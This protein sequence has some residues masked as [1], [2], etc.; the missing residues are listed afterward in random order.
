MDSEIITLGKGKYI[1]GA[2]IVGSISQLPQF[3][4]KESPTHIPVTIIN[5]FGESPLSH[6]WIQNRL[7]ELSLMDDVISTSFTEHIILRTSEHGN[8]DF[9]KEKTTTKFYVESAHDIPRDGP[10]FLDGKT[11]HKA[12][13]LYEDSYNA[14]VCG[15][16][17]SEEKPL[18]LEPK[19]PRLLQ[20]AGSHRL[21]SF[22]QFQTEKCIP[23][24]SR[25]YF[26]APTNQRPLS[27]KRIAVK[28]IYDLRGVPT[29]AGCKGYGAYHGPAQ[30]TAECIQALLDRGAVIVAKA[31][32]VQFASGMASADWCVNICPTNP[33]GD[34]QL[35]TDCSSSG[36]A[37]AVAGYGWLD[38]AIG[39]DS[40]SAFLRN[41]WGLNV[42][43]LGSMTGPAAACGI[44][45]LRPS[46]GALSN[47]GAVPVS[48]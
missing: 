42:I 20:R 37:A 43:G 1:T 18:R 39:S 46:L 13:R 16:V 33:R 44:F 21:C 8:V 41:D 24:P 17:Q 3:Q 12:Y 15:V 32:T 36:S 2:T 19:P 38:F 35:D 11:L 34:G 6:T 48:T 14:F 23:V 4:S 31:K 10:Y 25:C 5:A 26:P 28:D 47:V 40:E 29:A 27:G 22:K 45:G 7:D 9:V 30:D